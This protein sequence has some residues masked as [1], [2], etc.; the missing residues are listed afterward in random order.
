MYMQNED[1]LVYN[2]NE[3]ISIRAKLVPE[4]PIS[5]GVQI[6]FIFYIKELDQA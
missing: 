4:P 3:Y 2:P 6:T 1:F 5:G